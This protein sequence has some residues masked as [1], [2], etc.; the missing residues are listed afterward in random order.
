MGRDRLTHRGPDS[1]GSWISPDRKVSLHHRRLS[2]IDINSISD[3]PMTNEN[4]TYSIV[5]NGEIYNYKELR[6]KLKR[7]GKTFKT[8]SDTEVLLEAYKH[9]GDNCVE[10]LNGMF[11][12]AIYDH[13]NIIFLARD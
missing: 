6:L 4:S 13:K 7:Y 8:N 11:S 9:W 2:I 5:F 12:F 3:Q 10:H 1:F